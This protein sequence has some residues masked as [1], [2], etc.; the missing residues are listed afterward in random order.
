MSKTEQEKEGRSKREKA[1]VFDFDGVIHKYSKGFYDGTIYDEEIPGIAMAIK[2][3]K[4]AGYK[5]IIYSS[6][7]HSRK[8]AGKY[9]DGQPVLMAKWMDDRNIPYDEIYTGAG[10]PVCNLFI[11]DNA[12]RFD[13]SEW[14]EEHIN[15]VLKLA[16]DEDNNMKD[17]FKGCGQ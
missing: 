13:D 9:Q 2:A 7:N 8:Y 12:Y 6:R 1:I 14:T 4:K 16:G 11:D 10:K 5:I 15:N 17:I 3:V